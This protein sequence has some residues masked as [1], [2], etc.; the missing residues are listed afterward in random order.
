MAEAAREEAERLVRALSEEVRAPV[1]ALAPAPRR[2]EPRR[3][4]MEPEVAA[5]PSRRLR[6]VEQPVAE[7]E[8]VKWWLN[9]KPA[10]KRR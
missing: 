10:S 1:P 7:P 8:P 6:V 4:R 9:T 5:A 2:S 3:A